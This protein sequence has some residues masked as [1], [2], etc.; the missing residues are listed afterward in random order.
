MEL[1]KILGLRWLEIQ[2]YDLVKVCFFLEFN[3][4]FNV[5]IPNLVQTCKLRSVCYRNEDGKGTY[6]C[7]D[8]PNNGQNKMI[9][10]RLSLS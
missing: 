1:K 9:Y 5:T 10:S 8:M 3:Q 6:C 2:T 4:H 7:S